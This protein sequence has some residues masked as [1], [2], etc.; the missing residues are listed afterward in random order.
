METSRTDYIHTIPV[1]GELPVRHLMPLPTIG[2]KWPLAA[3]LHSSMRTLPSIPII[4]TEGAMGHI[5]PF[6]HVVG[7]GIGR[8]FGALVGDFVGGNLG[9]R[10]G[11]FVGSLVGVIVGD[12]VGFLVGDF[13]GDIVG[14]LVGGAALQQRALEALSFAVRHS[15]VGIAAWAPSFANVRQEVCLSD[16]VKP[17][18][19][20]LFHMDNLSGPPMEFM[21]ET[22]HKASCSEKKQLTFS[23]HPIQTHT[24]G[25]QQSRQIQGSC[26]NKYYHSKGSCSMLCR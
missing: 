6:M 20:S 8:I 15:L 18:S 11:A 4:F 13:V 23:T 2:V 5:I 7:V 26:R 19:L 16:K 3:D 14:D 22:S 21:R 10:V 9:D 25:T 17:E 24:L 12:L 1:F